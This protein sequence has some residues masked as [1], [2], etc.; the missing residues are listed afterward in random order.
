MEWKAIE[1]PPES[2]PPLLLFA[3]WQD[4]EHVYDDKED[5]S[6]D[7]NSQPRV[8]TQTFSQEPTNLCFS[9]SLSDISDTA[10]SGNVKISRGEVIRIL[11]DVRSSALVA[12]GGGP[13]LTLKTGLSWLKGLLPSSL[14]VC[15]FIIASKQ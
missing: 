9:Q 12:S 13:R 15:I 5:D 3:K 4:N 1:L 8:S 10:G 6:E 14:A 11:N 2:T 7:E